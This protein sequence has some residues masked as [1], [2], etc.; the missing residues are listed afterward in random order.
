MKKFGEH[1]TYSR[2]HFDAIRGIVLQDVRITMSKG[3][4]WYHETAVFDI[5]NQEFRCFNAEG[6]LQRR[7]QV[8]DITLK[9][10]PWREV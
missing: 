2:W 10:I 6:V 1:I 7:F 3:L 9:G 8:V 5:E 4:E